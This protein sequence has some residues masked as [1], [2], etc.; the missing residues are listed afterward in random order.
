MVQILIIQS[1]S[2]KHEENMHERAKIGEGTGNVVG[3]EEGAR[4]VRE[5]FRGKDVFDE[6]E[7]VDYGD[8]SEERADRGEDKEKNET[9][10]G[11]DRRGDKNRC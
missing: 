9:R 4:L 2:D 11:G 3:G 10:R 1:R 6:G 7:V 5:A 8:D